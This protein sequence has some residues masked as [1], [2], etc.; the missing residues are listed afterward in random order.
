MKRAAVKRPLG[1]SS[2][3]I[4]CALDHSSIALLGATSLCLSKY[5]RKDSITTS[6]IV[7]SAYAAYNFK[8]LCNAASRVTERRFN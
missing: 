6:F 3:A 2:Y 4:A 7:T 1:F 8:R 5:S